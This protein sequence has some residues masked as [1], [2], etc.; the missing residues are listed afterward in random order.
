VLP[1]L[2]SLLLEMTKHFVI[3]FFSS[4]DILDANADMS[5]IDKCGALND[6]KRRAP[7]SLH[8][9]DAAASDICGAPKGLNEVDNEMRWEKNNNESERRANE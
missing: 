5:A 2:P 3:L 4:R 1:V 8:R 9:R 7:Y 6:A